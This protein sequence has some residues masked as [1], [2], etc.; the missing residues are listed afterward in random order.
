MST[1]KD[2]HQNAQY[3]KQIRFSA[4]KYAVLRHVCVHLSA[5]KFVQAG[6][7]K[8]LKC[9]H[10]CTHRHIRWRSQTSLHGKI[11]TTNPTASVSSHGEWNASWPGSRPTGCYTWR[12]VCSHQWVGQTD[13]SGQHWPVSTHPLHLGHLVD[14]LGTSWQGRAQ[15]KEVSQHHVLLDGKKNRDEDLGLKRS[16]PRA[17]IKQHYYRLLSLNSH[18]KA[19]TIL[20]WPQSANLWQEQHSVCTELQSEIPQ[21]ENNNNKQFK[22]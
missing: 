12:E 17:K 18:N 22:P 5:Q 10:L 2:F 9:A 1:W 13:S 15:I 7:V 11:W 14:G 8:G 19:V 21:A 16:E 20:K 4:N 6:A 3:W